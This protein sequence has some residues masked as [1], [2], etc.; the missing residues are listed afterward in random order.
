MRDLKKNKFKNANN[1]IGRKAKRNKKEFLWKIE[2][3]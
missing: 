1:K 3:F 2:I